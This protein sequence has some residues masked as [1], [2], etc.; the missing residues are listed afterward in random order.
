MIVLLL[1]AC[2]LTAV[3]GPSMRPRWQ[4]NCTAMTV[5]RKRFGSEGFSPWPAPSYFNFFGAT[6]TF[7][8]PIGHVTSAHGNHTWIERVG[9]SAQHGAE[10]NAG[11]LDAA[12]PGDG[13]RQLLEERPARG[14]R[15][16]GRLRRHRQQGRRR[17]QGRQ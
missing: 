9:P 7:E 11:D 17:W 13:L 4:Y 8:R 5:W 3:R 12:G 15:W 6:C 1:R 10:D 16:R 14:G 2:V